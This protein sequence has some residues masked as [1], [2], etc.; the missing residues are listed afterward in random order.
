MSVFRGRRSLRALFLV[1]AA[2]AVAAVV[3]AGTGAFAAT[4]GG[5]VLAGK[6]TL[7]P[8]LTSKAQ[9]VSYTFTGTFSQ[10][11]GTGTVKSGSVTASGSGTSSCTANTTS[12]TAS[13]TWNTGQTS[14]ISFKTTGTGTL[15]QVA[16]TFTGGL[17]AGSKASAKL[18]FY[19]TTPQKCNTAG[20]LTS[21]S[22]EGPSTIGI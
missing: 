6:A 4:T 17:F 7:T 21:A 10:C 15:V 8:G 11:K 13:V 19:T 12:G 16:G 2:G 1:V 9:A 14:T 20:G 18:L 5:C 22:F 3:L